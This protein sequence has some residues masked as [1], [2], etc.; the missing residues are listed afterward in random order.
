[1]S[2]EYTVASMEPGLPPVDELHRLIELFFKV[3]HPIYPFL[4][5]GMIRLLVSE[6]SDMPQRSARSRSVSK[7]SRLMLLYLITILGTMAGPTVFQQHLNTYLSYCHTLVGHLILQ[8]SIESVQALLLFSITLRLRDQLSQ[9]WDV[10]TLAI[11]MSQTLRLAHLSAHL[12]TIHDKGS[13]SNMN[14]MRTWWAL[15]VF[16]K[17]LAFDSGRQ[18]TLDDPRLSSV[19]RQ[20]PTEP[21]N[22]EKALVLQDYENFLT[23]LANVLREMQHR[24]WHTWRTESLD[25]TSDADARASKIRTAG[26]IDTLL[27]EWRGSLPSEYQVGTSSS[28]DVQLTPQWAFLSF[29]YHQAVIVLYRNTLLLDWSEVKREV[30]RY[31]SGEPWHLRLRNGPQI[32]LEAAKGMTNLQVM[33]TEADEPSFLVLGTLP[34]AAAYV[35]AVHIR[36][37]PATILSRTHFELMKAAMAI[38]RQRYSSSTAQNSLHKSLDAL[39]R[40][41]SQLLSDMALQS[42]VEFS[43]DPVENH[44]TPMAIL[45]PLESPPLSWGSF[46]LLS[47]DW[48]DLVPQT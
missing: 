46:D 31:G 10:L 18:S 9:A 2:Y 34:L 20:D 23:S 12:R 28:A 1:M 7:T 43:T 3:Y 40:Y 48:N 33:V 42:S 19:G 41:V 45:N 24:S 15:Y 6:S 47:W 14:P 25:T 38:S 35:L 16:E 17:F 36:R 29:Y 4:D 11:S 13:G 26:A 39:E 30:D 22:N 44:L 27:W 5:R 21:M 32:C 37:Q 8:P